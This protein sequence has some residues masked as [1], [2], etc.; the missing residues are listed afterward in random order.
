MRHNKLAHTPGNFLFDALDKFR[1]KILL[2]L[3]D[4][5]IKPLLRRRG[6]RRHQLRLPQGLPRPFDFYQYGSE[7]RPLSCL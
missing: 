1:I 2:V 7:L 4:R 5:R 3:T 6:Q